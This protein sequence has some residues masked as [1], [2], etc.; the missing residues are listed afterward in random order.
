MAGPPYITPLN[1][2]RGSEVSCLNVSTGQLS[3]LPPSSKLQRVLQ[4]GA[5]SNPPFKP[6][7]LQ[8]AI[9]QPLRSVIY[10]WEALFPV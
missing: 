4:T 10:P 5:P 2:T 9:N 1:L 8:T 6:S 7:F 3:F